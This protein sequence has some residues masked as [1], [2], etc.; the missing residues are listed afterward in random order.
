MA[1]QATQVI[2]IDAS[3]QA[4]FDVAV[5]FERYPEWTGDIKEVEVRER[6]ADGR[7]VLVHFRTA[8]YGRSTSYLLQYDYREAPKVLSWE[9]V[10]GDLTSKLDGAYVFTETTSPAT[11]GR[12]GTEVTY[13]LE[14]ELKLPIP[15]FVKRRAEGRIMHTAL[16]QLKARVE[17]AA[18]A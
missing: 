2:V 9:E 4:C 11:P 18:S 14:A 10:E 12:I 1:E 15:G 7:G 5:A 8:A 13:H 16:R 17:A 6:D 3:P